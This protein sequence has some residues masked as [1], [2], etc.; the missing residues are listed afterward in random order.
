MAVVLLVLQVLVGLVMLGCFIMVVIRMFQEDQ[1]V[2]GIVCIVLTF[3]TGVGWLIA[4]VYG[5]IKVQEWRLMPIMGTWTACFALEV[6]L[7]V[8]GAVVAK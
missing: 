5:W 3:C 1:T 7:V 4:F 6:L 8:A 2:L